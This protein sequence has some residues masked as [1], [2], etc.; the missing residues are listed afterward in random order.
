MEVETMI[1]GKKI[2][3]YQRCYDRNDCHKNGA[4]LRRRKYKDIKGVIKI[5]PRY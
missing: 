3:R 1:G 2:K 5:I 4:H